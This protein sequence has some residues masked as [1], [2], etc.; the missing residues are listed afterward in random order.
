MAEQFP[1]PPG[2][3][4]AALIDLDGTLLDTAPDLAAAANRMLA[5]LGRPPRPVAEVAGYVG[6][7]IR[8]LVERC[9]TGELDKRADPALLERA[10]EH[11]ALAYDEESGRH[12]RI[13]P[14]VMEG[15]SELSSRGL[16]L[17]CVTNKAE[18]FT[19]PLLERAGLSR[20]FQVVVSGD[21]VT[22]GKPDP[23]C[24][25]LACER[26]GVA[27]RAALVIGDSENDVLAARAA[28]IRVICV[29]YGYRE[30]K[31]VAALGADAIV[32]DLRAL[33]R[34]ISP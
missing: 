15:L 24:Y 17:A 33:G 25:L 22:R 10:L 6:K 12:C 13:Y 29:S 30:G 19:L 16:L 28:G 23:A 26:L 2:S 11:F 14:G 31:S 1:L 8:R 9:L 4:S 7:G 27:P 34:L 21:M 20:L 3:V 32:A 18:R 5:A